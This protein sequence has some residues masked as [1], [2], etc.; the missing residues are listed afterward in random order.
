MFLLYAVKSNSL[1]LVKTVNGCVSLL[2]PGVEVMESH[3]FSAPTS[4]VCWIQDHCGLTTYRQYVFTHVDFCVAV[5]TPCGNGA[6]REGHTWVSASELMDAGLD[7]DALEALLLTCNSGADVTVPWMGADGFEPYM[8]WARTLLSDQDIALISSFQQIKNAFMSSVFWALTSGGVVY[9]K[10]VSSVYVARTQTERVLSGFCGPYPQFLGISPDG[11][12]S[13]TMEMPGYD[14]EVVDMDRLC[15]LLCGWSEK[16]IVLSGD[17]HDLLP[18]NSL[19]RLLAGLDNL[20]ADVKHIFF[21]VGTPLSVDDEQRFLAKLSVVRTTLL[22][23]SA[24]GIP[25]S[26]CHADIRPGNI[27]VVGDDAILYDW[28]LAFYGFPFYDALHLLRVLRRGLTPV[29][30]EQLKI[31]YLRPWQKLLPLD[32]LQAAWEWGE[33]CMGYFMLAADC[34]WVMGILEACGGIPLEGTMDGYAFSCRFHAFE[35][36]FRRFISA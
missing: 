5:F 34:R 17:D 12:A 26:V 1:F 28:G 11:S 24:V 36:V 14:E 13:L 9:L 18:D 31:A 15:R 4:D 23:L 29:Q 10:I 25:D 33:Q 2:A 35:K 32:R 20:S 16:Q 27:R 19:S 7:C 30:M 6:P 3:A 21:L 8:R 22:R